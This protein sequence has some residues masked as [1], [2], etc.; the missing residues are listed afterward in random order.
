MAKVTVNDLLKKKSEGR[1]ITM[2]TAYDFP[3]ARIAD[4]AGVDAILVGDSLA[5][6]VQGLDNTLPVTMD[7]MIYH[8]RMVSRAAGRA[9]VIGDM[10]F[11]SYQVSVREA[12][13]NAGRFLKEAGAQAVKVEGGSEVV[14]HIRAMTSSEIPVVAHVGL[15]P[16]AIHRMGGYKVQGRTGEARERLKV[17]ARA[18]QE[19]G[20]VALIL[21]AIPM[22]LARSITG[23]LSIPTIGIGA[24]PHCDGQVLVMHDVLG[25][26]ERFVP[27]FVKRYANLKDEALKALQAYIWDVESGAFPSEEQSFK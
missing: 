13:R 21:E 22:D 18:V 25:L 3:F 24:G 2:I 19:A 1:K 6:V 10:P 26:F 8:T 7:E 14:E 23:E 16:Q 17:D 9:M 15:T 20:A 12:V 27:K 5:M 11:L 4:E